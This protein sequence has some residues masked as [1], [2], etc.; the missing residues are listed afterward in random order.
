MVLLT[1]S[2]GFVVFID[3]IIGLEPSMVTNYVRL[4]MSLY[5]G[6]NLCGNPV[7]LTVTAATPGRHQMPGSVAIIGAQQPIFP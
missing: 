4:Q 2:S 6:V 7:S 3:F 5:R 1:L